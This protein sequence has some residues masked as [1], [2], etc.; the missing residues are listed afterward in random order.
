MKEKEFFKGDQIHKIKVIETLKTPIINL[1]KTY[2]LYSF[3][4]IIESYFGGDF[5]EK[6]IKKLHKDG[7]IEMAPKKEEKFLNKKLPED[8]IRLLKE[9]GKRKPDC[10][11]RLTPKGIDLAMSFIN[12]DYNKTMK[13]L[14]KW[15]IVLSVLTFFVAVISLIS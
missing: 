13:R 3:Y 10:W 7:F 6:T 5:G 14:T 15:I 9:E 11:Y 4:G 8:Q 12:L 1:Y 2:P